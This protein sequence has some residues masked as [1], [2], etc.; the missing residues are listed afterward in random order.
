METEDAGLALV[1]H[2]R[3]QLNNS[4]V[5]IVLRTGQPGMAPEHDVILQF[6]INGCFLKTEITAQ[7][8]SSIAFLPN[9]PSIAK[10]IERQS[11]AQSRFCT[12]LR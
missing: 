9:H 11:L 1:R 7:K 6:E 4:D 10:L 8:L 12:I 2:I 5:Q 3:D